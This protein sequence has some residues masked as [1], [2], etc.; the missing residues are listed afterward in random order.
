M[1]AVLLP[2][3]IL[4]VS[5]EHACLVKIMENEPPLKLEEGGEK[6]RTAI[7]LTTI[8]SAKHVYD[9][10]SRVEMVTGFIDQA[11]EVIKIMEQNRE[12]AGPVGLIRRGI[13]LSL[14]ST[15]DGRYET[16]AYTDAFF[17]RPQD[18]DKLRGLEVV[19]LADMAH[20]IKECANQVVSEFPEEFKFVNE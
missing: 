2:K 18:E 6:P 5:L 13:I 10:F 8:T 4:Q 16:C 3:R 1:Q 19:N 14:R 11:A 12:N 9:R 7:H 15:K 20:D 17:F